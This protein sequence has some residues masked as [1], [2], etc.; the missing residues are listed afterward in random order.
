MSEVLS[1]DSVSKLFA[2]VLQH[3]KCIEVR[4]DYA[5]AATSQKQKYA[6]K[7]AVTKVSSAIDTICGLLP[8]SDAVLEV[9]RKLDEADLVYLMVLTEQ[10]FDLPKEDLEHITGMI[11]DYL[12]KKYN[13][14]Q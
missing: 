7:T 3:M 5:R 2:N 11:D 8:D 1:E 14:E 6:L 12:I 4:M 13:T 10:L 9:K